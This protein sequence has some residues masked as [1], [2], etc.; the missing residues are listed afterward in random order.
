MGTET[1]K[2]PPK[3]DTKPHSYGT[4]VANKMLG[5]FEHE[6]KDLTGARCVVM[7]FVPGTPQ[8]GGTALCGYERDS[9]AIAD[10][11]MHLRAIMR[12]NGKDLEVVA[13]PR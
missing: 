12:A 13:V 11:L 7:L 10:V 4:E 8:E 3:R 6:T 2:P 1:P 9:D 5:V